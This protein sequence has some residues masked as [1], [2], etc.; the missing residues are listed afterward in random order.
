MSL[1]TKT[2]G[3][4]IKNKIKSGLSYLIRN[5]KCF[6]GEL[7]RN[8]S[9]FR[10]CRSERINAFPHQRVVTSNSL[11]FPL[12]GRPQLKLRLNFSR[13]GC[14]IRFCSDLHQCSSHDVLV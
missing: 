13:E 12:S 1:Q 5:I 8:L 6:K 9:G 4:Y 14:G 7:V 11:M 3:F 2:L 10:S